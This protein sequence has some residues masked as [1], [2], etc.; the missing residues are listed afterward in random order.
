MLLCTVD[1]L[2]SWLFRF[3]NTFGQMMKISEAISAL[4]LFNE[5]V[6]KLANSS[7]V[8]D[9]QGDDVG[10]KNSG[11]RTENGSFEVISKRNGPS[12]ESIDVFALT[13]RFFVQNNERSSLANVAALYENFEFHED[14]LGRFNSARVAV[15]SLLNASN[16]LGLST[17]EGVLTNRQI[18][19]VYLYGDLA[20]GQIDKRDTYKDWRSMPP[21]GLLTEACFIRIGGQIVS[22]LMF[23]ASVNEL[24]IKQLKAMNSE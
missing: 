24:A 13:L 16:D 14:L 9:M 17:D 7:F 11:K 2:V 15:N 12:S 22:A 19:D 23:I 1:T 6:H 8:R 10:V 18:L 5:K 3:Y 21:F 4:E 20:H